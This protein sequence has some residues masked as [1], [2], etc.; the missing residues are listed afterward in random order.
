MRITDFYNMKPVKVD[1]NLYR[2]TNGWHCHVP[3]AENWDIDD[4]KNERIELRM[5]VDYSFDCERNCDI[6]AAFLDGKPV[7]LFRNA[8]R[9]GHDEYDTFVTDRALY[10]EMLK[11]MH[12]L[13][14]DKDP[15]PPEYDA[16]AELPLLSNFYGMVFP[17]ALS[18]LRD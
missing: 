11:Y 7:L 18:E 10:G 9:G 6:G 4:S 13:R 8:G 17:E 16:N 12:S 5:Y 2:L 15:E 14:T 1:R 3:E